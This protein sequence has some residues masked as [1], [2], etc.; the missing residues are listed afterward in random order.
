MIVSCSEQFVFPDSLHQIV[1]YKIVTS[2]QY[3]TEQSRAVDEFPVA[4]TDTN[5]N[6]ISQRNHF[7]DN[8]FCENESHLPIPVKLLPKLVKNKRNL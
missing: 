6:H 3:R 8:K 4:N 7:E 2:V 5:T 1:R